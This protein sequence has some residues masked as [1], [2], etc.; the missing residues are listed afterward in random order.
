MAVAGFIQLGLYG[1][2]EADRCQACHTCRA[3]GDAART[4]HGIWATR[5]AVAPT[6][7]HDPKCGYGHAALLGVEHL[8]SS[9]IH[10]HT[11][12]PISLLALFVFA[13]TWVVPG[14]A[15]AHPAAAEPPLFG[16]AEECVEVVDKQAQKMLHVAYNVALDDT[17]LTQGDIVL[18]DAKTHQFFAFRGALLPHELGYD[19]FGFAPERDAPVVLPEWISSSDVKRAAQATN[20]LDGTAFSEN[21]IPEGAVLD[22]N[23]QLADTYV[24]V[25]ADDARVPITL[26][27]ALDGVDWQLTDV[28]PGLYT[29]AGYIFSPP[30]NAWAKRA[31]LIEV[32]EGTDPGPAAQLE[33]IEGGLFPYQGRIVRGCVAA[34]EGSTVRGSFLVLERPEAGWIEWLPSTAITSGAID[35]CFR[36]PRPELTGSVRLRL[37]VSSAAGG[38]RSFYSP[39]TVT[40]LPGSGHCTPSATVCCAPETTPTPCD[41]NDDGAGCVGDAGGGPPGAADAAIDDLAQTDADLVSGAAGESRELRDGGSSSGAAN[42]DAGCAV[43]APTGAQGAASRIALVLWLVFALTRLT[44]ARPHRTTVG[45]V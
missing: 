34:R 16:V 24:R 2:R 25:T 5:T 29:F 37:D 39:D 12:L 38:T 4:C 15:F 43:R 21:D 10:T 28:A 40:V 30:Y 14:A 27:Q 11:S 36:D 33:P 20:T 45:V 35:L 32:V 9:P 13:C 8:T 18:P 17:A 22:A 41:P 6:S 23:A 42:D 26:T 31:Q 3:T 7:E 44:R 1:R 19:L